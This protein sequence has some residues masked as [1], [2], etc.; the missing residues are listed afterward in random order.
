MLTARAAA[1]VALTGTAR[2]DVSSGV[3][4]MALLVTLGAPGGWLAWSPRLP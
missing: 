3:A 2:Q 1:A 4:G